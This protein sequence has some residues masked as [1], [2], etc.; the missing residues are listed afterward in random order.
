MKLIICWVVPLPSNSGNE[1]LGWDSLLKMVH[2]PGGHYYWEGAQPKLYVNQAAQPKPMRCKGS[3]TTS[4]L[5]P[6]EM[7][8]NNANMESSGYNTKDKHI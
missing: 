1:G 3:N 5:T 7:A 2:N 4:Q 6:L 8:R